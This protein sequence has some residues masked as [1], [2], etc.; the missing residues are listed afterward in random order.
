M[1]T[2][3]QDTAAVSRKEYAVTRVGDVQVPQGNTSRGVNREIFKYLQEAAPAAGWKTLLDLPCGHGLFVQTINRHLPLQAHGADIMPSP[4]HLAPHEYTRFDASAALAGPLPEPLQ[5]RYDVVTCISG[6][7]EFGNTSQFFDF[8][9]QR[10]APGGCFI[11]TNDSIFTVQDRLLYLLLGRTRRLKLFR[12]RNQSVWHII[13]MPTTVGMLHAAG[14]RVERVVHVLG[15]PKDLWML[16]LAALL[17]PLLRL[18]VGCSSFFEKSSIDPGLKAGMYSF[19]SL[20]CT[21][22]VLICRRQP[23]APGATDTATRS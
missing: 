15:K 10:L 7:M 19:R 23:D 22:Y 16:P 12:V 8:C 14:F 1:A 20:F 11:V 5:G 6:I 13:P 17:Y 9:A 18:Y 2:M 21:S 4:A 3:Q